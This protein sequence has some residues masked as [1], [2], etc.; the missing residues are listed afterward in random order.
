MGC[1]HVAHC[2]SLSISVQ[3]VWI[4]AFVI[5]K[6]KQWKPQDSVLGV[7]CPEDKSSYTFALKFKDHLFLYLE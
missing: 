1:V 6:V 3:F 2:L 5:S 4:I 7:L